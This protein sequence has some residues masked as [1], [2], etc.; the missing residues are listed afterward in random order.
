MFRQLGAENDNRRGV[1]ARA[2]SVDPLTVRIGARR[3]QAEAIAQGVAWVGTNARRLIERSMKGKSGESTPGLEDNRASTILGRASVADAFR[4][5]VL[6]VAQL[7]RRFILEP[8]ARRRRR[9][10]AV[11]QLKTLDDRLL[12]DIGLLRGE[13]ELAVD[14]GLPRRGDVFPPPVE[15]HPLPMDDRHELAEAA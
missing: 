1:R 5:D 14:G 13:I 7:V 8:Y 4:R 11:A 3:A 2:T 6:R 15:R 10:I 12:A 9:R